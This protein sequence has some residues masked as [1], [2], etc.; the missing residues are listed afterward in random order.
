MQR[1]FP[2]KP[3]KNQVTGCAAERKRRVAPQHV[4]TDRVDFLTMRR[5]APKHVRQ[6]EWTFGHATRRPTARQTDREGP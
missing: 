3:L 5:V 6:A 2:E 4:E 1:D